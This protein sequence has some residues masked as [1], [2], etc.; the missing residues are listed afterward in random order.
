MK[1]DLPCGTPGEHLDPTQTALVFTINN[2]TGTTLT[3]DGSAAALISA[4]DVYFGSSHLSSISDYN[5]LV[6]SLSDFTGGI[7]DTRC[8]GALRGTG[9]VAASLSTGT[10]YTVTNGAVIATATTRRVAIPLCNFLGSCALKSLPLSQLSD[11]LRLEVR[12][13]PIAEYGVWGA[14][15]AA[16]TTLTVETPL[17]MYTTI[18]LDGA[19]EQAMVTDLNG[20]LECP[21]YDWRTFSTS[22]TAGASIVSYQIPIKVSSATMV[23]VTFRDNASFVY[24]QRTMSRIRNGLQW[25]RFRIGSV[26]IPSSQVVCTESAAEARLELQRAFLQINDACP[27]SCISQAQYVA[28]NLTAVNAAGGY[29]GFCIGLLLSALS[30]SDIISDGASTRDQ[31]VVFEASFASTAVA[32]R[33]NVYVQNEALLVAQGRVLNIED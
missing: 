8:G 13:A 26:T 1:F 15:P 27:R 33:M 31:H 7:D 32:A 2:A 16:F 18:K 24:G 6:N 11:S 21:C 17:L 19:V 10:Q 5:N 28:D 9:D 29:G 12:L 3:L 4:V 22:I 30:A 25:Y 23:L 20:K 14:D